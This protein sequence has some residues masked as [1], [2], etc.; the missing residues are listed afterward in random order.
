MA[1]FVS[2]S[3]SAP[4]LRERSRSYAL[5]WSPGDDEHAVRHVRCALELDAGLR[6][7]I[8]QDEDFQRL[9]ED[10]RFEAALA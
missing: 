9:R 2:R 3:R 5:R 10:P 1:G 8:A 4:A 7:S 6:D